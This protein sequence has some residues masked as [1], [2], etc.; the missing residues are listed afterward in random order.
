MN[1]QLFLLLGLLALLVALNSKSISLPALK[2][3]QIIVLLF[4]S[5]LI[6]VCMNKNVIEGMK[7]DMTAPPH[8]GTVVEYETKIKSISDDVGKKIEKI[9]VHLKDILTSISKHLTS[10]TEPKST[11]TKSTGNKPKQPNPP[12]KVEDK[13]KKEKTLAQTKI[14]GNNL[15]KIYHN[16]SATKDLSKPDLYKDR[17]DGAQIHP[18]LDENARKNWDYLKKNETF[19]KSIIKDAKDW[20]SNNKGSTESVI[21]ICPE[22][23]N[24]WK[25]NK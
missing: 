21:D 4:L 8:A 5:F 16:D 25:L 3:E 20:L 2:N 12:G 18:A 19:A 11:E 10:D 6:I 22:T 15:Y 9:Q 24:C 1:Q 23:C 17:C 13:C 7:G 14:C